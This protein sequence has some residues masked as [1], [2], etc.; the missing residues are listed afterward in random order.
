MPPLWPAGVYGLPQTKTGCPA[1]ALKWTTGTLYQPLGPLNTISLDS[2]LKAS[3]SIEGVTRSFCFKNT[4]DV[5][6]ISPVW[7]RGSY[8]LYMQS[9]QCPK[10]LI[11]GSLSWTNRN[12]P[13]S[14]DKPYSVGS[15]PTGIYNDTITEINYC[16][17]SDRPDTI[18][19]LPIDEPFILLTN[20]ADGRCQK[21]R[22]ALSQREYIGFDVNETVL[23]PSTLPHPFTHGRNVMYVNFCYYQGSYFQPRL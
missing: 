17:S 13:H 2:H 12:S 11:K 1:A 10:G 14:N 6:P 4:T 15:L 8:C 7:P 20:A 3:A 16:C 18:I 23:S 9:N 19:D 5:D 22:D 21:V